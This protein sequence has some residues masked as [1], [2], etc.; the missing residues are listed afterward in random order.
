MIGEKIASLFNLQVLTALPFNSD[1]FENLSRGVFVLEHQKDPLTRKF[2]EM[3]ENM[4]AII[5]QSR[6]V[7]ETSDSGPT[8]QAV[9]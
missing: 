4:I 8:R 5:E 9:G 1:V 6:E 2:T 7:P 3:A